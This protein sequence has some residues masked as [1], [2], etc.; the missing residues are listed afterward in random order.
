MTILLVE[1]TLARV[2][3]FAERVYLID[4]GQ[5]VA[6]ATTAEIAKDAQLWRTYLG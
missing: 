3:E 1:E 4:H 6:E 5:I 2:Q